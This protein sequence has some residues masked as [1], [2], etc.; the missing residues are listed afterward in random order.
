MFNKSS[1]EN[2]SY[3]GKISHSEMSD[4][5]QNATVCIFP[6]YAEA[7]PISWLEAMCMGKALATSNIG[8]SNEII[9]D[10]VNGLMESPSNHKAFA[11]NI[12]KLL[13][14]PALNQMIGKNAHDT[15]ISKFTANHAATQTIQFY[16]SLL[17]R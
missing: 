13:N 12:L 10:Q 14:Q 4:Y 6:S 16:S 5:I 17:K 11:A 1:F 15:I 8:W 7:F 2:I 9:K 3:L